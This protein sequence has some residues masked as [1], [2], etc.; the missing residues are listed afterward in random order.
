MTIFEGFGLEEA[1]GG[2]NGGG[3]LIDVKLSG[4]ASTLLL[5]RRDVGGVR[6]VRAG[7]E[8]GS[9]VVTGVSRICFRLVLSSVSSCMRD[10]SLGE[11][12]D[13]TPA[14]LSSNFGVESPKLNGE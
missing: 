11:R 9:L 2:G 1:R 7:A 3:A 14:N 8:G 6:M 12:G 4:L 10:K 5:P 13:C